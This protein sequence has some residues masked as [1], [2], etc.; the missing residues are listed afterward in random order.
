MHVTA[1][2]QGHPFLEPLA[3]GQVRVLLT[4]GEIALAAQVAVDR[5]KLSRLDPARTPTY[6]AGWH[7]ALPYERDGVLAEHAMAKFLNCWPCGTLVIGPRLPGDDGGIEIKSTRRANGGLAVQPNN[8]DGIPAIL[9]IIEEPF[10]K[11]VGWIW[12]NEAKNQ[13]WW[14]PDWDKPAFCVPQSEL[15]GSPAQLLVWHMTRVT[16]DLQSRIQLLPLW[17][18]P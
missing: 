15:R 14:R 9:T 16:V 10:V 1:V 8:R 18:K 12:S 13:K 4:P 17:T 7:K 5:I 11:I 6:D 2:L 3:N